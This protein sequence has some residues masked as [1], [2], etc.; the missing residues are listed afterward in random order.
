MNIFNL[1]EAICRNLFDFSLK[2]YKFLTIKIKEKAG[3]LSVSALF[4]YPTIIH[5][6]PP[7]AR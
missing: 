5:H 7:G 3:T 1:K 2:T 4:F 6:P